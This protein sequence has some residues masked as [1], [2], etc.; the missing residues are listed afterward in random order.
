MSLVPSTRSTAAAGLVTN[1]TASP[2]AQA[3]W[4]PIPRIV[5]T[6]ATRDSLSSLVTLR[7]S[8]T[9]F[10]HFTL[11][12]AFWEPRKA[13]TREVWD[14]ISDPERRKL[15]QGASLQI[16]TVQLRGWCRRGDLNPHVLAYTRPS[17]GTAVSP[18]SRLIPP[19]TV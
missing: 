1:L 7:W 5:S 13:S 17:T 2:S 4:N 11:T 18:P 16:T 10:E 19:R 8:A 12:R 15:S 9:R 14:P 3:C 6:P